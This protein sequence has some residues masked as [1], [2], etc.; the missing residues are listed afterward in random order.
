MNARFEIGADIF[1]ILDR[2]YE[3]IAYYFPTRIRDP[4]PGGVLEPDIRSDFVTHPGEPRTARIR[5]RARF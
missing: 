2:H 4:R 1:N 5:L 3:D